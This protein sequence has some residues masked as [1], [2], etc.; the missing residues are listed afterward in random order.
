MIT[1]TND[2]AYRLAIACIECMQEHGDGD[3]SSVS[4]I[5]EGTQESVTGIPWDHDITDDEDDFVCALIEATMALRLP[6]D[7]LER[8]RDAQSQPTLR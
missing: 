3:G 2:Q 8:I 4:E 7:E 5:C 6:N 1:L